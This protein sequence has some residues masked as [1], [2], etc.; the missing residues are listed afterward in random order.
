MAHTSETGGQRGLIFLVS[1]GRVRSGKPSSPKAGMSGT[2]DHS[3]SERVGAC[4]PIPAI[5]M[6]NLIIKHGMATESLDATWV[7]YG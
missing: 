3:G 6:A 2:A 4:A 1:E 5:G 7:T